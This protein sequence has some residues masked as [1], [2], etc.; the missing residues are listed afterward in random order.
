MVYWVSSDNN[1]Y[2]WNLNKKII[3]RNRI[4]YC[5]KS[6]VNMCQD[7][8][9]MHIGGPMWCTKPT[10]LG[11]WEKIKEKRSNEKS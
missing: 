5:N 6:L 3:R 8:A 10:T 11:Y 7:Y 9:R 4:S 1:R 2:Y